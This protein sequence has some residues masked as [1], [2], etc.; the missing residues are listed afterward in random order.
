MVLLLSIVRTGLVTSLVG[1]SL[2]TFPEFLP[3]MV[4]FWLLVFSCL[5][6]MKKKGWFALL[7]CSIVLVSKGVPLLPSTILMWGA[8]LVVASFRWKMLDV[9]AWNARSSLLSFCLLWSGWLYFCF[10]WN[11]VTQCNQPTRFDPNR[12]VVCVGDSLTSGMI[13]DPGYPGALE[14]MLTVPV[15]NLGRSG[16]ASEMGL[17]LM[18]RILD[19]NPQIVVIELGGHDFLKGYRRNETKQ[20]ILKMIELCRENDCQIVL[21]EIPRGF[22]FDPFR[23]LEREIAY[24]QDV[25]LIPDG[26]IRQLIFWSPVCPPGIW[27]PNSRL[28]DDGIH[29]NPLGSKAMAGRVSY[30]LEQVAGPKIIRK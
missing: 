1:L 9:P 16:I 8:M 15:F 13:P 2:L 11:Q 29:S 21:A 10:E 25:Q 3:V 17:E 18:P 6:V 7:I 28:S 30:A 27:S 12:P 23:G 22:M 5:V 4:L 24:E 20:N 26:M 14:A 19:L